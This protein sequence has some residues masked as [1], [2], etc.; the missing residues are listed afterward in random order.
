MTKNKASHLHRLISLDVFRGIAIIIM[1][2]VNSPG[3]NTAYKFLNH[4]VWNGCTLADL[5]FPFFV[6][7]MGVSLV[8]SLSKAREI[9]IS[10]KQLILKISKRTVILILIGL[11]LNAFPYH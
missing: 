1:I 5:A 3:N 9:G 10:T 2:L 6:F 7:I 11:F 4:S 8:F